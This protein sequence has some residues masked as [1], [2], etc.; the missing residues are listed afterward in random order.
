MQRFLITL[1]QA[2]AEACGRI[3]AGGQIPPPII[4][5]KGN[6]MANESQLRLPIQTV[7]V[8]RSETLPAFVVTVKV[9]DPSGGEVEVQFIP[10][11][12]ATSGVRDSHAY[13]SSEVNQ[14]LGI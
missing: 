5:L 2:V 1:P 10:E 14:R 3:E 9:R 7:P 12:Y 8:N 13:F 11:V 6:R 4:S